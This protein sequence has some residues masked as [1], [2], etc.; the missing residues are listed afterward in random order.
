LKGLG[1]DLKGRE[2]ISKDYGKGWKGL[3]RDER[4][5]KV[6]KRTEKV[7]IR[8]GKGFNVIG[9]DEKSGNY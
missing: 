9:K 6:L 2:K 1:F 4:T 8:T 7:L 5:E 3:E